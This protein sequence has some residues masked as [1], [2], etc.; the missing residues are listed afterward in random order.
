MT[1][2]AVWQPYL[3]VIFRDHDGTQMGEVQYVPYGGAA[4][5]PGTPSHTDLR[6]VRWDR[7]FNYI[8]QDT[9]VTAECERPAPIVMPTPTPL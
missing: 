6:F 7:A 3:R 9:I 8:V 2:Y 5:A 4:T 1:F